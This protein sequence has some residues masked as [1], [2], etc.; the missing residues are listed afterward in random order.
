[1][2]TRYKTTHET[3]IIN[4]NKYL[5]QIGYVKGTQTYVLRH[6]A[7]FLDYTKQNPQNIITSQINGFFEYLEQRPMKLKLPSN[8][9]GLPAKAESGG[10]GALGSATIYGYINSLKQFFYWL[11]QTEQI[12]TNPMSS[13][14]HKALMK[15]TRQPLTQ[16]QIKQLFNAADNIKEKIILHLF[17]SCGLRRAEA[18]NLNIND[19]QFTKRMLY[20][21]SGKGS[22]RR[23][24][25]MNEKVAK[26]FE[27]YYNDERM[28]YMFTDH[29]KNNY[30][31]PINPDY[32]ENKKAFVLNNHYT[33]MKGDSYCRVLKQII[34]RT[35]I[36]IHYGLHH[37]RHSIATHLLENGLSLEFIR[38]FLGHTHLDTTQIY[39]R[40]S[41]QLLKS[42]VREHH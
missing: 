6:I 31:L 24:I 15:N 12:Q 34:Q 32:E 36:P 41:A 38:D 3:T 16:L 21:R 33:R 40:V 11:E 28:K 2:M 35:D 39:T 7:E 10:R 19:V 42:V 14:V 5:H 13:F 37:L 30:N 17:Y 4:F 9:I 27:N 1:M 23:A 22:K 25:P 26:D 29:L 8:K 20:V 18:V